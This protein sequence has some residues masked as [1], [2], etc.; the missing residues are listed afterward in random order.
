[1][2]RPRRLARLEPAFPS[3]AEEVDKLGDVS[4][5]L[6]AIDARDQS[7]HGSVRH[8]KEPRG[9]IAVHLLEA[10]VARKGLG[11]MAADDCQVG[12]E[13]RTIVAVDCDLDRRQRVGIAGVDR[14]D[15]DAPSELL[16]R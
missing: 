5:I 16:G 10:R 14:L 15:Q 11:R 9:A 7:F 8:G 1:M 4:D 3:R 12:R 2:R 13:P 6:E